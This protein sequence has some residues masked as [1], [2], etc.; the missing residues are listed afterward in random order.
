MLL[1]HTQGN[2]EVNFAD[3]PSLLMIRTLQFRTRVSEFTAPALQRR[4]REP[5]NEDDIVS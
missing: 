2:R 5:F 3:P 1:E 4:G